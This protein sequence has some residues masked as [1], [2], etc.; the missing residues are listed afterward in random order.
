MGMDRNK[1]IFLVA[2]LIFLIIMILIG[3]DFASK[4]SFPGA[5]KPS[6]SAVPT[7]TVQNYGND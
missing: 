4:T 6:D 2:G 5:G 3:L 7:D 1:K